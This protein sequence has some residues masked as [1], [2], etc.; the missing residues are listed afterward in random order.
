[1]QIRDILIKDHI[2]IIC[3]ENAE[4]DFTGL[5]IDA[6][7]QISVHL[8]KTVSAEMNLIFSIVF[9]FSLIFFTNFQV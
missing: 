4:P 5:S 9:N 1:M 2:L 6:S 8:A 3:S 7:Y